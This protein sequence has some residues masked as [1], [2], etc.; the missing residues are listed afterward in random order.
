VFGQ[1]DY[2]PIESLTLTAGLRFETNTTH[3]DRERRFAEQESSAFLP[4]FTVE[5]RFNPNV[6]TYASATRGYRPGGLN[7]DTDFPGALEFDE[8][9]S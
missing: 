5:Y 9:M 2:Q 6:V 7:P 8:E 4:R 1:V 3:L